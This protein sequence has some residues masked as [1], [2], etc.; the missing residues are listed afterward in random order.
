[1]NV[2]RRQSIVTLAS[3]AMGAALL[4]CPNLAQGRDYTGPI[5][6]LVGFTPGGATD[7]VARQL[8][9]KL[10]DVLVQPIVVDNK[11]GAGGMI[12]TQLLKASPNDGSTIM[13]TIDHAH[14]IVPM[15]FRAP[16]YDP[17]T[18]FT[19]LAG[20]ANYYNALVV[21]RSI[22]VRTMQ[23][24][25]AWLK[26][27]PGKANYGVGAAGSVAQFSGQLIG[28]SIGVEMVPVPY[29]GGAPLV[30]DLL[31]GQIPAGVVSLT[32]A[33]EHH[34]GE[35][36]RIL[37]V[38]GPSRS[39]V[40]PEV[41]TFSELGLQGLDRNPWLAFFGPKGMPPEFV[42]RFTKAVAAVLKQPE[43][44][45]RLAKIGNEVLYATPERLQREWVVAAA[46]H[47]EPVIK[48]SGWV[49]Q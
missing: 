43:V 42:D 29:K 41:P 15:T 20:V 6:I 9:D 12:A 39:K 11:P 21:A 38:S 48:E 40:A 37:A 14:L 30:Q 31:A 36:L 18:D 7:V 22:N 34:R 19:P 16:G 25:S 2:N 17:I 8:G 13:L 44:N 23:E 26:A 45:E 33:I 28:K 24:F 46:K 49:P 4:A 27:N 3:T 10:K 1:M 32:D 47:W 5:R 35:K